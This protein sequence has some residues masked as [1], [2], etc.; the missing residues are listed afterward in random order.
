MPGATSSVDRECPMC[1][2]EV[3][4]Q[5]EHCWLC[6]ASLPKAVVQAE[7]TRQPGKHEGASGLQ[8]N[9]ATLAL[10]ITV[11]VVVAGVFLRAPGLGAALA[12]AI[13]PITLHLVVL[14]LLRKGRKQPVSKSEYVSIVVGWVGAT[15]VV[16]VLI[17][18]I[19]LIAV[20]VA[21]LAICS[22]VVGPYYQ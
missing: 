2:A 14:S 19:L 8:M 10:V 17:P 6:R 15:V 21:L 7:V 4:L 18:M 1:R 13:V 12:V 11:S 16:T 20:T 9:T 22:S 5:D 3:R